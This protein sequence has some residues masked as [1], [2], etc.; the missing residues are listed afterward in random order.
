MNFAPLKTLLFFLIVLAGSGCADITTLKPSK[1]LSADRNKPTNPYGDSIFDIQKTGDRDLG[2]SSDVSANALLWQAT[3]DTIGFMGI[4][5]IDPN[6]GV[7]ITEWYRPNG[8]DV[9]FQTIVTVS[10]PTLASNSLQ[11][12][13]AK[14]ETGEQTG[15]G[16][17]M[18]S[19]LKD[20]ILVKARE[21]RTKRID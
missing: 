13:V 20:A 2:T 8:T 1:D 5:S 9:E 19:K 7:I 4:R 21:K 3:L 10:R 11:V 6:K 18:A 17:A 15:S 12:M 16:E 14:K